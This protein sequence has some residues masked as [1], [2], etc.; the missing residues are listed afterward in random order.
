MRAHQWIIRRR[1]ELANP[2]NLAITWDSPTTP[3]FKEAFQSDP[4]IIIPTAQM[5]IADYLD[6]NSG[7]VPHQL[8]HK[9]FAHISYTALDRCWEPQFGIGGEAEFD[10][11]SE[12]LSGLNQW[13]IWFKWAISY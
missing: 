13:G 3:P 8:T 11:R 6:I 5:D 10:G 12:I 7:A 1:I 9:V 2:N 4:P